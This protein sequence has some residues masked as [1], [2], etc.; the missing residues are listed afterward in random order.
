MNISFN[1]VYTHSY[2]RIY[3]TCIFSCIKSWPHAGKQRIPC[4]SFSRVTM[5]SSKVQQAMDYG[6]KYEARALK[7][8]QEYLG[9]EIY[10]APYMKGDDGLVGKP[11]GLVADGSLVE[12]KCPWNLLYVTSDLTQH[13]KRKGLFALVRKGRL[14]TQYSDQACKYYTQCQKYMQILPSAKVVHFGIWAPKTK[15]KILVIDILPDAR[16]MSRHKHHSRHARQVP[17]DEKKGCLRAQ[18]SEKKRSKTMGAHGK[19]KEYYTSE[20]RGQK[21]KKEKEK[22]APKKGKRASGGI[23]AYV[24][25]HSRQQLGAIQATPAAAHGSCADGGE[26][27]VE[28]ANEPKLATDHDPLHSAAIE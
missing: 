1:S 16:W 9:Q 5:H 27:L 23:A 11:D 20:A 25:S 6:L 15:E 22:V 12:V 8:M 14:N 21:R 28:G 4:P 24:R 2:N 18:V 13:Y 10:P 17:T 7:C 26:G 3:F 19:Q